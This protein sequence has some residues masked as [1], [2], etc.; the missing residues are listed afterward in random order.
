MNTRGA[1]IA[2]FLAMVILG[3]CGLLSLGLFGGAPGP[4]AGE[5]GVGSSGATPGQLNV[6]FFIAFG[7]TMLIAAIVLFSPRPK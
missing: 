6:V 4:S 3:S 5:L 7:S 2:A 1:Y